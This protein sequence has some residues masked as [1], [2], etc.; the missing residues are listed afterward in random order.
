M[1]LPE[2]YNESTLCKIL[3]R[4]KTDVEKEYGAVIITHYLREKL[5]SYAHYIAKNYNSQ[6]AY[7]E[8]KRE[9]ITF[10]KSGG[11]L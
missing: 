7:E 11:R 6:F 4:A 10:I 1:E 5:L 8:L 3:E 2:G 9:I